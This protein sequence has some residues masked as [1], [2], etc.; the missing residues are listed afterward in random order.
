M[1]DEMERI[2]KKAIMVYILR[3]YPDI[4]LGRQKKHEN[5]QSG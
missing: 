3:H 2:W 5:P 1:N 4:R